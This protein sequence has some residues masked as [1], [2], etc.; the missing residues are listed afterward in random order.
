[1]YVF[2]SRAFYKFS[3]TPIFKKL[4]A[5]IPA[6]LLLGARFSLYCL[7]LY[8]PNTQYKEKRDVPTPVCFFLF[9]YSISNNMYTSQNYFSS[10]QKSPI[11]ITAF[12]ITRSDIMKPRK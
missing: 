4:D 2:L 12:F 3:L 10:D 8:S 7:Y 11:K 5:F 6:L 1:M 9:Y